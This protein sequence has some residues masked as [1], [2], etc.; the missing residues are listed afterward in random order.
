MKEKLQNLI[1]DC[2]SVLQTGL[3]D[4]SSNAEGA[5][6]IGYFKSIE[7]HN[8]LSEG[9]HTTVKTIEML[10]M[11]NEEEADAKSNTNG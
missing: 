7:R 10:V 11:L 9:V 8:K 5:D 4:I 2:I 6:D 1:N 3:D